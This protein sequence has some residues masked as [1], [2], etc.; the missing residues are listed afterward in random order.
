MYTGLYRRE[1]ARE[2]L[3]ACV[4]DCASLGGA[5]VRLRVWG[6]YMVRQAVSG[7]CRSSGAASQWVAGGGCMHPRRA[8]SVLQMRRLTNGLTHGHGASVC[9]VQRASDGDEGRGR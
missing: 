1:G 6:A 2:R 7:A 3:A 5:R 9:L 4:S 8:W